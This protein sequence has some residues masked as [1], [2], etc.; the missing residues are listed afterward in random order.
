MQ[1]IPGYELFEIKRELRFTVDVDPQGGIRSATNQSNLLPPFSLCTK[2]RLAP[3]D[4]AVRKT[5]LGRSAQFG[6][7]GGRMHTVG[8]ATEKDLGP[9]TL[10]IFVGYEG[11]NGER[12]TIALAYAM[13][14]FGDGFTAFVDANTGKFL[15]IRRN[16]AT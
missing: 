4:P 3:D 6:D 15:E 16:F 9:P 5:V 10:R 7:I 12:R 11:S 1:P 13:S 14:L 8:P 2:P